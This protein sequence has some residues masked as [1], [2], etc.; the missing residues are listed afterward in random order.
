MMNGHF[1]WEGKQEDPVVC[2]THETF[3]HLLCMHI[4]RMGSM[5]ECAEHYEISPTALN[6]I[7]T[8]RNN[9]TQ[10]MLDEMG[11]KQIKAFVPVRTEKQSE[12]WQAAIFD[13]INP[14]SGNGEMQ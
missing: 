5:K 3:R 10:K 12:E 8:G 13:S 1:K 7:K 9:P 14:L 11:L 2:L 6:M 4:A